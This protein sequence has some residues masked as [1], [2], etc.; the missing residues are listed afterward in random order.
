MRSKISCWSQHIRPR[1][2]ALA[3]MARCS[4]LTCKL[5][6]MTA[7]SGLGLLIAHKGNPCKRTSLAI[8]SLTANGAAS[9]V[10]SKVRAVC[11]PFLRDAAKRYALCRFLFRSWSYCVFP[12]HAAWR[13]QT[14]YA[15]TVHQALGT[16][17]VVKG[18]AYHFGMRKYIAF[19][20]PL[21]VLR[22]ILHIGK[23]AETTF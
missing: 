21:R 19:S 6:A 7:R 9:S 10:Y 11:S 4:V 1:T 23:P 8:A 14:E 12:H 20:M 17:A 5:A 18:F 22:N 13:Q 16:R 3:S 15:A 2:S